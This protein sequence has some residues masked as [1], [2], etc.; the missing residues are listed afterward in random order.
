MKIAILLL[1]KGRGSGEVAREHARHLIKLGHKVYL[2]HPA[3]GVGIDGAESIDI[4]LHTNITPVHEYLPAAGDTQKQVARMTHEEMLSYLPD[5]E[6]AL[7]NIIGD[8]DVVIGHHANLSAVA[9][10][11]VAK[12]NK[13]PYVI[14]V[15][16]TGIEPRHQGLWNDENWEMIKTAL[17]EASGLL[18]TTDYVRDELVKPLIDIADDKFLVLP[19][20]VDLV[21]FKP[22]NNDGIR[23]KYGLKGDYVICPGA[24]MA[25]KGPQNVVEASKEYSDLALTVFIG[26]GALEQELK[27]KAGSRARF[28]G[29][30]SSEDKAKLINEASLLV[31]APEK[32]EH[33]GIIYAEALAGGTPSVAYEGGGVGSI[34]TPTEGILTPRNPQGLGNKIRYL[35]QNIGQRK[36]MSRSC[37]PRAEKYYDYHLLVIRLVEWLENLCG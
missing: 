12:R 1:N 5:Y 31:A 26:A 17:T 14:F 10:H 7:E 21:D 8:V 29:F 13:K 9:V 3:M 28:L 37:R 16:G 19:C 23:E 2:M 32:K 15:H 18:V 22:G 36:Q 4:K 24:L 30:V 35:L 34:I 25:S 6:N 27:E 33:F 11:N 20:G